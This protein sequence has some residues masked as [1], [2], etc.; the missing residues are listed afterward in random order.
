MASENKKT[1][2]PNVVTGA[3]IR[4]GSGQKLLHV[5][6][7]RKHTST[8]MENFFSKT[9]RKL[10]LPMSTRCRLQMSR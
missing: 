4:D 10:W 2:L 7:L 6:H 1:Y 9:M 3:S 8:E 5:F